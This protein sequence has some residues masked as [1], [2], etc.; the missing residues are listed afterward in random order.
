MITQQDK[1][2][3]EALVAEMPEPY[4]PLVQ[5]RRV[6]W[7]SG[8]AHLPGRMLYNI[9]SGPASERIGSTVTAESMW[10]KGYRTEVVL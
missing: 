10:S 6:G 4:K 5:L 9:V 3:A 7:Q 1:A 2:E 8:F